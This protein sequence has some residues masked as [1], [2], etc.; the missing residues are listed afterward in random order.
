MGQQMV[1]ASEDR[2]KELNAIMSIA[3][4]RDLKAALK[5]GDVIVSKIDVDG[6]ILDG[7][8]FANYIVTDLYEHHFLCEGNKGVMRSFCYSDLLTGAVARRKS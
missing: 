4:F 2:S 8:N 5:P 6:D 7:G 1:R 3:R